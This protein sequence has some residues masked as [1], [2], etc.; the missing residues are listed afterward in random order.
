MAS[1]R[2]PWNGAFHGVGRKSD[3]ASG[4]DDTRPSADDCPQRSAIGHEL[5]HDLDAVPGEKPFHDGQRVATGDEHRRLVGWSNWPLTDRFGL[6]TVPRRVA[7]SAHLEQ[8]HVRARVGRLECERKRIE[9]A[10]EKSERTRR[11]RVDRGERP[12]AARRAY[13]SRQVEAID[14]RR[15]CGRNT[16]LFVDIVKGVERGLRCRHGFY[17][18]AIDDYV[19]LG[20]TGASAQIE[21]VGVE[22]AHHIHAVLT[23]APRDGRRPLASE[24][25]ITRANA[26]DFD[27][28]ASQIDLEYGKNPWSGRLHDTSQRHSRHYGARANR[29]WY[30][31]LRVRCACRDRDGDE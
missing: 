8:R 20:S 5:R 15:T 9:P 27:L 29:V 11:T 24:Q 22:N 23:H 7:S 28:R 16:E 1:A 30:R 25:M 13:D 6:H 12:F 18:L 14:D 21:E 2:E 31:H 19:A 3:V 26:S 10:R 4:I 17:N